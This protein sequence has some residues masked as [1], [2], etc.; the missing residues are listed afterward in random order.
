MEKIEEVVFVN[1]GVSPPKLRALYEQCGFEQHHKQP[2]EI[3][4]PK[5]VGSYNKKETQHFPLTWHEDQ[6]GALMELFRESWGRGMKDD[7]TSFKTTAVRQVY[8]STT[9][10]GII[11][12]WHVHTMQYDR[13]V[14][15]RG[16]ILLCTYNLVDEEIVV[17]EQILDSSRKPKTVIVPPGIVHGWKALGNE[18]AWVLN[19]CSKEYDG[20]DEWRKSP[21]VQ[22]R[23]GVN[24]YNW[25]RRVDG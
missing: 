14:C 10:P 16:S 11:K 25:N 3:Q 19:L 6:R 23:P 4:P 5:I 21:H 15:V 7:G 18:E 8:I 22:L 24:P 17:R 13:F 1:E 12:G 9:R 20:T 2:L